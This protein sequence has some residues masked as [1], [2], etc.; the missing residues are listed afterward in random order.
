M[1]TAN[2]SVMCG[3]VARDLA[4]APF[5]LASFDTP[6]T[7]PGSVFVQRSCVEYVQRFVVNLALR[8]TAPGSDFVLRRF[9]DSWVYLTYKHKITQ[10]GWTG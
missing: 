4:S 5:T 7:A 10:P 2:G 6:S 8:L 9:E 1:A 3:G